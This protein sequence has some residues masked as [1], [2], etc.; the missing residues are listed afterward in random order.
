MS[1]ER[2]R[3]QWDLIIN[4]LGSEKYNHIYTSVYDLG[5]T[6]FTCKNISLALYEKIKN[7]S[8]I[9]IICH[10]AGFAHALYI[11]TLFKPFL[12]INLDG[13]TDTQEL[14][15]PEER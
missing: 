12:I 14:K 3:H 10:S 9:I 11:Q 5:L 13:M 15:K 6:E 7:L 4:K 8:N 2:K 1:S